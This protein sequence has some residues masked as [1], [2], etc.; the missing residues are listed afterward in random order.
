MKST[1]SIRPTTFRGITVLLCCLVLLSSTLSSQAQKNQENVKYK[2]ILVLAKVEQPDIEKSF[3]QAMVQALKDKG[4]VAIPSFGTFSPDEIENTTR[5]VQKADS[6]SIDALLAF[7]LINIET[8][9]KHNPQVSANVGVPVSIGFFSVF[10]GTSVPLGGGTT[11]EKR[12][13]VEV[14]FYTDRNSSVPSWKM[15]LQGN[16]ADGTNYLIKDF[17]RKTMK[18]LTKQKVL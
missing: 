10:V 3:E 12:V 16:L 13:N 5:L 17:V 11:E 6:L 15:N 1:L 7:T 4:Y 8:S 18:A 2:K 14:G 9:V